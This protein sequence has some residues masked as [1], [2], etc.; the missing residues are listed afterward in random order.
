MKVEMVMR[1]VK[2]VTKMGVM[3]KRFEQYILRISLYIIIINIYQIV[4]NK[5][6]KIR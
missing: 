2:G 3:D 1:E 5:S 4:L 6:V